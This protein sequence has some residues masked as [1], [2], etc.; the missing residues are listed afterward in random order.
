MR[1]YIV[2]LKKSELLPSKVKMQNGYAREVGD[3]FH[4]SLQTVNRVVE[5]IHKKKLNFGEQG[6][7]RQETSSSK[8]D[9][10]C[11]SLA[12]GLKGS[13]SRQQNVFWYQ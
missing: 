1:P 4:G 3:F 9:C 11:P 6:R 8:T 12:V 7:G 5:F 13:V 2:H 10:S